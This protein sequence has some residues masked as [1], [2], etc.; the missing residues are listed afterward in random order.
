MLGVICLK[1]NGAMGRHPQIMPL[2]ISAKLKVS[3]TCQRG[4][5]RD[6]RGNIRPEGHGCEIPGNILSVSELHVVDQ[7][8][9]AG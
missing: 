4:N 2:E 6:Q 7:A 5:E 9:D 1:N 8:K 3:H